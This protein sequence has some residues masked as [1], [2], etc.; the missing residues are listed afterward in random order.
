MDGQLWDGIVQSI[1]TGHV[2]MMKH[3][4]VMKPQLFA[5]AG[6]RLHGFVQLWPVSRGMD[7]AKGIAEMSGLASAAG[8]DEVVVAWETQ[9]IA[10]ACD[11]PPLRPKP[12]V[13]ILW[14]ARGRHLLYRFPYQEQQMQG[15]TEH[16]LIPVA[17][18]W[19]APEPAVRGAELE[20]AIAALL[21]FS[22]QPFDYDDPDILSHAAV[23]LES[24]GYAVSLTI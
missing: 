13:N 3:G 22:F 4:L 23:Y 17:A 15:R 11:L 8:A 21:E 24:Q 9:D 5:F 20:P 18:R 1:K 12:A 10:I 19:L 14:A 2:E 6:G 7:A 16:G